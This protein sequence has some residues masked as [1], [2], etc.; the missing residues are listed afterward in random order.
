[1]NIYTFSASP[2]LIPHLRGRVRSGGYDPYLGKDCNPDYIPLS[3]PPIGTCYRLKNVIYI[4]QRQ[5]ACFA[6]RLPFSWLPQVIRTLP[7]SSRDGT[8]CSNSIQMAT[9]RR[10]P[11]RKM[12]FWTMP[13]SIITAGPIE[14]GG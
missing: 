12:G 3:R 13:F 10:W 1:M 8:R 4:T 6:N 5:K 9:P 7:A 14:W 2:S 11:F